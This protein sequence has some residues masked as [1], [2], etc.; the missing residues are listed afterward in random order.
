[1]QRIRVYT[2]AKDLGVSSKELMD[3]LSDS[4]KPVTSHFALIDG[5]I[6]LAARE[7]FLGTETSE[8]TEP[9]WATVATAE[10]DEP[11]V[12]FFAPFEV[13]VP[14]APRPVTVIEDDASEIHDIVP[15]HSLAFS[16]AA[17]LGVAVIPTFASFATLVF[18]QP[19]PRPFLA[20]VMSILLTAGAIVLG[21]AVW[22]TQ[23]ESAGFSFGDLMLWSW[24][25]R[26]WAERQ[27]V[28]ATAV[29]GFDRKGTFVGD[30]KAT[31]D[32]Q[33][34][35]VR[36]IAAALDAKCSYTLGHSR[37]VE[38]HAR[39]VAEALGLS[40]AETE[41]LATAAALH[42][43]GNISIPDHLLR[44]TGELTIDERMSI[45]AHVLLGAMMVLKAGSEDVVEGIRHHH[46]RLDGKGYPSGLRRDDIPLY[47]RIIGIAEAYD[48]MTSTRPYRQGFGREHAIEVLRAEAGS[49]F[50]ADLVEMFVATLPKP[51]SIVTRFPFLQGLQRQAQ[52]LRLVFKR[53]GA[54]A[55]SATASTI[56]IALILGS[57]I[58]SNGVPDDADGRDGRRRVAP[59][60]RVLGNRI[61]ADPNRIT[62]DFVPSDGFAVSQ[63]AAAR[64][65]SASVL[66]SD[67]GGVTDGFGGGGED[68][69]EN[70]DPG[71]GGG[72]GPGNGGGNGGGGN[73]GGNDGGG[74]GVVPGIGGGDNNGPTPNDPGTPTPTPPPPPPGGGSDPDDNHP[75]KGK[76][77]GKPEN[78]GNGHGNG[79]GN[80][81]GNAGGN[82]NGNGGGKPDNPGNSGGNGNGG[83]NEG[84]GNSGGNGNAGGNDNSNAGGNGNGNG[85]AGG[86]G[87]GNGNAGGNENPGGGNDAPGNSDHDNGNGGGSDQT[88]ANGGDN[89]NGGGGGNDAPGNSDHDNGNSGDS[90]GG[91]NSD[92]PGNS[93]KEKG[94]SVGAAAGASGNS[95]NGGGGDKTG[96]A[97]GAAST[98]ADAN[99]KN[100]DDE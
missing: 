12:P 47:A 46:E 87:N 77:K 24:V 3:F 31:P 98:S 28:E 65:T 78:P 11:V 79:N 18:G 27:L 76:G 95:G 59:I 22:N 41:A 66:I 68:P 40:F 53:M 89:G 71:N 20:V 2:V 48:A 35:A 70:P 99:G 96:G 91:G 88:P 13:E 74:G 60:D 38:K 62:S 4:G 97:P 67:V 26:E 90:G 51:L 85:N 29:L 80:G 5:S 92:A 30:T 6:A 1:M 86:N 23:P 9:A 52:E 43:I 45:E 7:H 32:E 93:D 16:G 84:P 44:K 72:P 49:Q 55:L 83:G 8:L 56:A 39:K 81:N 33:M 63:E 100:K 57:T 14:E 10:R 54:V 34:L 50:D 42:D 64:S 21:S 82:G 69:G 61:A 58:L 94:G 37:R 25:R 73:G 17:T 36:Q 19:Y 75:G 15:R